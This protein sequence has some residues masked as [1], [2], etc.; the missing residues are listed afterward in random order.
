VPAKVEGTWHFPEGEL[1]LH[2][3][4]QIVTGTLTTGGRTTA[5]YDGRLRGDQITFNAGF[6]KYAGRVSGNQ[7][8]G[9]SKSDHNHAVWKAV[10]VYQ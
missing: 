3:K 4:Y 5:I 9:V 1:V 6:R 8:E 7:I 2:Q 10:R